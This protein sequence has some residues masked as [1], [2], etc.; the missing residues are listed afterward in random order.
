MLLDLQGS[1]DQLASALLTSADCLDE[2]VKV[3]IGIHVSQRY[4]AVFVESADHFILDF[5]LD[6]I[7]QLDHGEPRGG[8]HR[9]HSGLMV[10]HLYSRSHAQRIYT[11]WCIRPGM[12]KVKRSK[13]SALHIGKKVV[14]WEIVEPCQGLIFVDPRDILVEDRAAFEW[15]SGRYDVWNLDVEPWR[16]NDHEK[17]TIVV[18][19]PDGFQEIREVM[20]YTRKLRAT[21]EL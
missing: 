12:V 14:L 7:E 20:V 13:Y 15:V 9:K 6:R 10:K 16:M 8:G 4:G 3:L 5:E 1:A 19:A 21:T 17:R 11:G 18:V 2:P